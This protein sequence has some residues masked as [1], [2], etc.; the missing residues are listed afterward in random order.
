MLALTHLVQLNCNASFVDSSPRGLLFDLY[1]F[2]YSCYCSLSSKRQLTV[3]CAFLHSTLIVL[4][5]HHCIIWLI[6][7]CGP[8]I[9]QTTPWCLYNLCLPWCS[10]TGKKSFVKEEKMTCQMPPDRSHE[11]LLAQ[12]AAQ[13]GWFDGCIYLLPTIESSAIILCTHTTS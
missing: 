1:V 10:L 12:A 7:C 3:F 13:A 9:V 11:E 8:R 6:S 4:S 2:P 5:T